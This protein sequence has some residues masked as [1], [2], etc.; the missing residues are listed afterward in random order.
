[1]N[2]WGWW[3]MQGLEEKGVERQQQAT[4]SQQTANKSKQ[5]TT[6]AHRMPSVARRSMFGVW[7][8]GLP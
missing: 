5:Q 6:P 3:E 4:H 7:M 8:V 1:M 2:L